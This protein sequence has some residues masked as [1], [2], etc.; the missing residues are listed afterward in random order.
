MMSIF[1][2]CTPINDFVALFAF[3]AFYFNLPLLNPAFTSLS[4]FASSGAL[5]NATIFKCYNFFRSFIYLCHLGDLF[6]ADLFFRDLAVGILL[7]SDSN[8]LVAFPDL[9]FLDLFLDVLR[10]YRFSFAVYSNAPL[11]SD[12]AS[13]VSA[14]NKIEA[15]GLLMS[16][17]VASQCI[18]H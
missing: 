5:E 1:T 17:M 11:T 12:T 18:E 15:K 7:V 3:G 10:A 2:T 9:L 13:T 16:F 8:T 6:L 14:I 4:A